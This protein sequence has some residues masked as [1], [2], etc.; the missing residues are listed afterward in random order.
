M[1][2]MKSLVYAWKFIKFAVT[3]SEIVYK[4]PMALEA[5]W[6]QIKNYREKESKFYYKENILS[7]TFNEDF[8]FYDN[9]IVEVK[10][11]EGA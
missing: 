6:R 11:Q 3:V 7:H 2:L 1:K 10:A 8:V 9:I 4:D 5:K